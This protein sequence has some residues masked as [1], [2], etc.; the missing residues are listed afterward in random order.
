MIA[1]FLLSRSIFLVLILILVFYLGDL[2][3]IPYCF[4]AGLMFY[5]FDF[6]VA[7]IYGWDGQSF[8]AITTSYLFKSKWQLLDKLNF[9]IF[10]TFF[11]ILFALLDNVYTVDPAFKVL[12][13]FILPSYAFNKLLSFLRPSQT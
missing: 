4:I 11:G 12:V 1:K 7:K 8:Q 9:L 13:Y 5:I 10:F 3:P 6:S 2:N